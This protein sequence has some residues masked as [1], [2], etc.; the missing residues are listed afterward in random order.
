MP[1]LESLLK[2]RDP[3]IRRKN[4]RAMKFALRGALWT[5]ARPAVQPPIFI[6]GCSRAG[7]TVTYEMLAAAPGLVSFGYEL[8][9]FWNAMHGPAHNGWASEAADEAVARPEFRDRALKHCY[10]RLGDGRILDKTCINVMRI[11]FLNA[12]FPEAQF[13]YIHRDGRDNVSSM[14]DGWRDGRFALT[15][16]LGQFPEQVR[17]AGGRYAEWHFFLPPGWRSYN[18]ATLEQACAYQWITANELA[19][20]AK[21]QIPA[22]RWIQIRYEDLFDRPAELFEDVFR[23]LA[24]QFTPEIAHRSASLQERPTSIVQGPPAR[25]KWKQRNTA[26]I[27]RILPMIAPLMLRLGYADQGP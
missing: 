6:V 19:L 7:T 10:A 27:E 24:L 4:L 3:E 26:A 9:K 2:I 14:M 20:A 18:S 16:F 1:K 17:I 12:L 25:A 11:P 23:R 8:P 15:Q 13:V 21:P 22:E 5:W